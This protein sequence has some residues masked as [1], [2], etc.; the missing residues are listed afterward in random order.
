M[1]GSLGSNFPPIITCI[2]RSSCMHWS[3][4]STA[5]EA[6]SFGQIWWDCGIKIERWHDNPAMNVGCYLQNKPSA[7]SP[8]RNRLKKK[9][10]LSVTFWDLQI[11]DQLHRYKLQCNQPW[12]K[13]KVHQR[14]G[15]N[16]CLANQV[17]KYVQNLAE[18]CTVRWSKTHMMPMDPGSTSARHN[19]VLEKC[20]NVI[21]FILVI[22]RD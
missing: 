12:I 18:K 5:L 15:L 6:T 22:N 7:Q 10:E 17:H 2:N 20:C 16:S 8:G 11:E 21:I 1:D 14:S 4:S 19:S 3:S 9:I 13:V